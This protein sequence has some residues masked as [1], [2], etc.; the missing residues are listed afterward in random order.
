M[1][2][3][4]D[5]F[6]AYT[7]FVNKV[8]VENGQGV[9]EDWKLPG[10]IAPEG[11]FY[12]PKT[13]IKIAD[14]SDTVSSVSMKQIKYNLTEG[15]TWR[16]EEGYDEEGQ[17]V[18]YLHG[19]FDISTKHDFKK[20]DIIAIYQN[21]D[22][23]IFYGFVNDITGKTVDIAFE[24]VPYAA[25]LINGSSMMLTTREY[26]APYAAFL[27]NSKSFVWRELVKPSELPNDSTLFDRPFANGCFYIHQN[28]NFFLKRQDP[29]NAFGLLYPED[30]NDN[31]EPQSKYYKK[32]GN[33]Q[34]DTSAFDIYPGLLNNVCY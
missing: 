4:R 34:I 31:N 1:A 7:Y 29:T 24:G 9:K 30:A 32:S 10:N 33:D 13:P 11:Y 6:S 20:G 22:G 26:V 17:V 28:V 18:R 14:V 21:D 5:S 27:P 3:S 2:R 8:S 16:T 12:D 23:K 25:G 19:I 15:L